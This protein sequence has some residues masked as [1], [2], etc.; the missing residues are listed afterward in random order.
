[1]IGNPI[2]EAALP[3]IAVA[4]MAAVGWRNIWFAVSAILG[5]IFLPCLLFLFRRMRLVSL[6]AV[7]QP[8]ADS[9]QGRL[10]AEACPSR[11]AAQMIRDPVFYLLL[12]GFLA[13]VFIN[14]AVFFHQVAICQAEGWNPVWFVAS[15][16]FSSVMNICSSLLVGWL[17]DR[18]GARPILA[19]LLLP[20]LLAL[21]LLG[22]SDAAIVIP[23][24]LTLAGATLGTVQPF[25]SVILAEI[26]GIEHFGEIRAVVIASNVLMGALGPAFVGLLVDQ[27]VSF[28]WA[29]LGMALYVLICI[30]FLNVAGV[31][32]R[33]TIKINLG[34]DG[35]P[36]IT[37]VIRSDKNASAGAGASVPPI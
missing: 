5:L 17:L 3:I 11:T 27:G 18:F 25:Q 19:F 12:P 29:F 16:P 34:K 37:R 30:A 9:V 21:M 31:M 20:Q 24:Y 6:T 10:N 15:Y 22:T 36:S 14:T 28:D 13:P 35:L 4:A 7:S 8:T 26:Y 1:M 33:R 2:G 23:I 32:M